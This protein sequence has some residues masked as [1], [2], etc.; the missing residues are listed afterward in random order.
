MEIHVLQT[1]QT[2]PD[3]A[4][5]NLENY[6]PAGLWLELVSKELN[7]LAAMF[8]PGIWILWS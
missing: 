3:P 6:L 8:M 1:V 5:N 2:L 7:P 4:Q